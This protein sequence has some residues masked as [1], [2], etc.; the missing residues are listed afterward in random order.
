M[1]F[2]HKIFQQILE[3]VWCDVTTLIPEPQDRELISRV[4]YDEL[5]LGE[6]REESKREYLRIIAGLQQRGAGGVILACTEI[7]LLIE[8]TDVSLPLFDTMKIH[9]DKALRIATGDGD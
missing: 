8:Q 2:P 4:V 3:A 1:F 5:A 7:P 6:I 9:A